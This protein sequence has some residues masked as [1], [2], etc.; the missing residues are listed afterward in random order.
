MTEKAAKKELQKRGK[1]VI[2]KKFGGVPS[3]EV[4]DAQLG[5]LRATDQ[6]AVRALQEHDRKKL[7]RKSA[8]GSAEDSAEKEGGGR[9]GGGRASLKTDT[10]KVARATE[11]DD[12]TTPRGLRAAIEKR[13]GSARRRASAKKEALNSDDNEDGGEGKIS[14]DAEAKEAVEGKAGEPGANDANAA[15]DDNGSAASLGK[16]PGQTAT[17]ALECCWRSYITCVGQLLGCAGAG[18]L[19]DPMVIE[20]ERERLSLRKAS[21]L[22]DIEGNLD[23]KKLDQT[24]KSGDSAEAKSAETPPVDAVEAKREAARK[25]MAA[26]R[27]QL[28]AGIDWAALLPDKYRKA[29]KGA[30]ADAQGV[31]SAGNVGER[32]AAVGGVL[33]PKHHKFRPS[34][35]IT[36]IEIKSVNTFAGD[37][38]VSHPMVRVFAVD[39]RTGELLLKTKPKRPAVQSNGEGST[40]IG[41]TFNHGE[42][43]AQRGAQDTCKFVL[44][45]ITRPARL[46]TSG[47]G[48]VGKGADWNEELLLNFHPSLL[49]QPHV[50]LLAEIVDFGSKIPLPQLRRGRGLYSIAW[51]FLYPTG[52]DGA[53]NLGSSLRMKLWRCV[54]WPSLTA[55]CA[56]CYLNGGLQLVS[57][58]CP[59]LLPQV[60]RTHSH[61]ISPGRRHG[62]PQW[63]RTNS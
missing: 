28:L 51:G 12:M 14:G 36:A 30:L 11:G 61:A 19:M 63:I 18:A 10:T 8:G 13:K 59:L 53:P 15:S 49:L 42:W 41:W 17:P 21:I 7:L 4:T 32:S 25:L 2:A 6:D 23:A 55:G 35:A 43:V 22:A 62:H 37:P 16:Q 46:Q 34:K 27:E 44:P 40:V 26:R 20:M 45:V 47:K 58:T 60:S 50:L 31:P 52:F 1:L 9:E 56:A 29:G 54:L 24:V 48:P 57:F 38:Y 39:A 3:L 5:S 33:S